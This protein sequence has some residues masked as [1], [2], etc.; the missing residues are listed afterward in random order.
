[1]SQWYRSSQKGRRK[2]KRIQE[3]QPEIK[4]FYIYNI[5]SISLADLRPNCQWLDKDSRRED[6]A[7]GGHA[8]VVL[9]TKR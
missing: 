5:S 4:R 3:G 7:A 2:P 9:F 8:R 1:M 6:V